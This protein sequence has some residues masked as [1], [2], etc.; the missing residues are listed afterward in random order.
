MPFYKDELRSP[1]RPFLVPPLEYRRKAAGFRVRVPLTSASVR[2]L[3]DSTKPN[4]TN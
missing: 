4:I 2:I 3:T 1:Q